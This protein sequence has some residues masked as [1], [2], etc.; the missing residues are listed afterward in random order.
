MAAAALRHSFF[1]HPPE[2][3]VIEDR[4]VLTDYTMPVTEQ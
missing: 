2:A 3:E 1:L 4:F